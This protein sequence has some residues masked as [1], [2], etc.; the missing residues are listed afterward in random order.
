M[1]VRIEYP[2]LYPKIKIYNR[3]LHY[4]TPEN[5]NKITAFSKDSGKTQK[6][7]V[8]DIF[9]ETNPKEVMKDLFYKYIDEKIEQYTK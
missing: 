7:V 1:N 8:L 3:I 4:L 5:R 9:G 6:E 2:D